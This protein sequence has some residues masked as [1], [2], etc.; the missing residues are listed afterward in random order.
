MYACEPL[1]ITFPAFGTLCHCTTGLTFEMWGDFRGCSLRL[2]S[3]WRSIVCL[4][5]ASSPRSLLR[6]RIDS[7]VASMARQDLAAWLVRRR[8]DFDSE[9]VNAPLRRPRPPG[10]PS[11]EGP[12]HQRQRAEALPREPPSPPS[13]DQLSLGEMA[14]PYAQKSAASGSSPRPSTPETSG[15][16]SSC[17]ESSE[18]RPRSCS[19][20]SWRSTRLTHGLVR[21]AT[22]HPGP[23]QR[24]GA[25]R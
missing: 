12:S 10:S 9:S 18:G 23:D 11:S 1:P 21:E 7:C 6:C 4:P 25:L 17:S 5:V 8:A 14:E 24:F 22:G 13:S 19:T 15:L 16:E 20:Q 3:F 2:C